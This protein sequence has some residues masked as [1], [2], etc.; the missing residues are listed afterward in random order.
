MSMVAFAETILIIIVRQK[1]S[2]ILA[3][4]DHNY[5]SYTAILVNK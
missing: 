1:L 5:D 4:T 3:Y 2:L